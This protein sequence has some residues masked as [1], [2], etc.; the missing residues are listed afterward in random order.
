[1]AHAKSGF[2]QWTD[3][4]QVHGVINL[5][6]KLHLSGL[7]RLQAVLKSANFLRLANTEYA[8]LYDA[9]RHQN[10][11]Q[12]DESNPGSATGFYDF[13]CHARKRAL[14]ALGFNVISSAFA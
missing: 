8:P 14:R 7:E 3:D 5:T 10:E 13:F 2:G 12:K 11:T 6:Q 4:A 1:M 9:C